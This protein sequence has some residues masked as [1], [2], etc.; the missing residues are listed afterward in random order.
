MINPKKE[1]DSSAIFDSTGKL[2]P[3]KTTNLFYEITDTNY[4]DFEKANAF[5]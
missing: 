2:I 3:K 5:D 1:F 4:L